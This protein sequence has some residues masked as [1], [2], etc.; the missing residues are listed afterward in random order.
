VL[1]DR[2]A[3]LLEQSADEGGLAVVC[4]FR[5]YRAMEEAR[6]GDAA[7]HYRAGLKHAWVAGD[8]REIVNCLSNEL[9]ALAWG[10]HARGRSPPQVRERRASGGWARHRRTDRPGEDSAPGSD[11]GIRTGPVDRRDCAGCARG[12]R[13]AADDR[14]SAVHH[15][16]A[17]RTARRGPPRHRTR[18]SSVL[19]DARGD[20]RSIGALSSPC[21]LGARPRPA[22]KARGSARRSQYGRADGRAVTG[23]ARPDVQ[24]PRTRSGRDRS[25]GGGGVR[26]RG[27]VGRLGER[28][29]HRRGRVA[30][31]QR[32]SPPQGGGTRR[33]QPGR[34]LEPSSCASERAT[35]RCR[36][37]LDGSSPG[38]G[39]T[40]GAAAGSTCGFEFDWPI[41]APRAHPL[42]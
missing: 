12:R 18:P 13:A 38:A 17:H 11:G 26:A 22:G 9:L 10:G 6:P 8:R 2:A 35:S 33:G 5:G 3:V 4:R 37:R 40:P 20:A 30:P 21:V 1:L 41:P 25:A 15:G 42:G 34:K 39:D 29:A 36:C 31:H 28:D 16:Q 27:G 32:R 19:H 23:R 7:V 24:R 14:R